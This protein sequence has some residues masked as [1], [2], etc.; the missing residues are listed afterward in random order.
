ME[1]LSLIPFF[2]LGLFWHKI[3]P[4]PTP[5]TKKEWLRYIGSLLLASIVL[6][7][8]MNMFGM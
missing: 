4:W 1:L 7:M 8:V 6:S 3:S 5:T 2:L